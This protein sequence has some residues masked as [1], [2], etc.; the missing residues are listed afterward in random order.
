MEK[1]IYKWLPIIF[2]CH[3]RSDRSFYRKGRKFP[4]CARC[5]GEL[6]GIIS[7]AAAYAFAH[8]SLYACIALMIPMIADGLLQLKTR[9][10]SNNITRFVTGFLFGTGFITI[11]IMSFC[12]TTRFGYD[13]GVNLR[14]KYFL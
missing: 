6:A 10:E 7:A 5:T 3:C 11:I 4:I 8:F 9:Y 1:W 13:I 14:E 12:F 2:G